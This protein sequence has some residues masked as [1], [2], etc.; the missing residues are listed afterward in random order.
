MNKTGVDTIQCNPTIEMREGEE[1]DLN[2][3]DEVL[4]GV[5]SDLDGRPAVRQYSS[6]KSNLTYLITYLN[7]ELV[8]RRPPPGIKAASAHSMI[9]EYKIL[10][11]LG[12]AFPAIPHVILYSD[13]ESLLGSEFYLMDKVEGVLVK[14]GFPAEWGFSQSDRGRFCRRVFDKLIELH[15][16]DYESAGLKDF[17]KPDGYGER[18]IVG[19]NKRYVAALTPDVPDFRDVRD[20][21]ESNI[22]VNAA[23]KSILH[24]DFRIDNVMVSA[25][26]PFN[27]VAVLDWEMAALGDPLMDLANALA[28]WFHSDDP[29]ELFAMKNQPSDVNGMMRREDILEYYSD[30]TGFG[31]EKWHF[32]EVYGYFRLAV[33][34]QQLYFRFVSKQTTDPRFARYGEVVVHIGRYC[35]KLIERSSF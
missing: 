22:P 35:Q 8:L 23:Y 2:R 14:E 33:I 28:Y 10:K 7:R 19:W 34:A 24:G 27:V 31:I 11:L 30:K 13:D 25:D 4:K 1:L 20:W 26:D 29:P 21:L 6:G 3:L 18:Q 15:Q 9:R 17:G 32:Y 12:D 5:L 16:V